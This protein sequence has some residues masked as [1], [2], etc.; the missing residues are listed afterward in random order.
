MIKVG[1]RRLVNAD[2][3]L[4]DIEIDAMAPE[5]SPECMAGAG[6][7]VRRAIGK[8]S[9]PFSPRCVRIR[10]RGTGWIIYCWAHY[11]NQVSFLSTTREPFESER[12]F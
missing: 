8:C 3:P 5:C 10:R 4:S 12:I 9:F 7:L 6:E 11:L 2:A 1:E